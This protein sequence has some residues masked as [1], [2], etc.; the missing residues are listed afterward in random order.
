[1][2]SIV[3]LIKSTKKYAPAYG[4][5]HIVTETVGS[6]LHPEI[7][8]HLSSESDHAGHIFNN[9]TRSVRSL[10]RRGEATGLSDDKPKKGSSRAVLFLKQPHKISLDGKEAHIPTVLKVAFHG[11]LDSYNDSGALLGQHQN[12]AEGSW[13]AQKHYSVIHE[14]ENGEYHTNPEGILPP[15]FNK[16]PED[17]WLHVARIRPVRAGEYRELT[18]TP[19][20]PKGI[21]HEEMF[22]TLMHHHE[23]AHGRTWNK[24]GMNHE[25]ISGHPMVSQMLNFVADEGQ[26]PGDYVKRNM[27]VFEHPH[28]SKHLVI[29]DYGFSHDVVKEYQKAREKWGRKLR[30]W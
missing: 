6:G 17:H 15:L 4:N 23:A 3:E 19:D 11:H 25:R 20:F 16:H 22:H 26:H 10:I 14:G 12:A 24:K 8:Q 13:T 29:S 5:F 7:E 30:G 21:S 27:G 2:K 1:M 18:K 28:G 9:V